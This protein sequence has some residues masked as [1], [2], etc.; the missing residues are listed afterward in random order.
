MQA[1]REKIDQEVARRFRYV[2]IIGGI[3]HFA[4]GLLDIA[5]YPDK[6]KLFIWIRV[7]AC[8][9]VLFNLLVSYTIKKHSL[10]IWISDLSITIAGLSIVTMIYFAEGIA[11]NYYEGLNIVFLALFGANCFYALHNLCVGLIIFTCYL[12]A[13]W[14]NPQPFTVALL[15]PKVFFLGSTISFIYMVTYFFSRQS[16]MDFI[17]SEQLKENAQTLS[18]INQK[19]IATERAKSEFFAN[20]S[21]EL[22]TPL[23]LILGPIKQ[24]LSDPQTTTDQKHDLKVMQRN[25]SVLLK[26]VNELLDLARLDSSKMEVVWEMTDISKLLRFVCGHFEYIARVKMIDFKIK[27][28]SSLVY[29]AD[30]QKVERV[31]F[32]LLSNAFKF[33]PEGGRIDV[34]IKKIDEYI[35]ISVDDSGPGIPTNMRESIFDRF[36]QVDTGD[37]RKYGGTGLGLS[38][39]KE[40]IELLSGQIFVANTAKNGG[41]RIIVRLVK[42]PESMQGVEPASLQT[43][44]PSEIPTLGYTDTASPQHLNLPQTKQSIGDTNVKKPAVLVVEDHAD[45][46]NFIT[47]LLSADYNVMPFLHAKEALKFV[48]VLRPDL[49]ITDLMMPDFSGEQ[50]I[51]AIRKDQAAENIPI[52]VLT[53]KSDPQLAEAIFKWGAQDILIKPFSE[54]ELKA[55]V[56]HHISMK[57]L[58][59]L[60]ET[61]VSAKSSSLQEMAESL[62]RTAA[63][64]TKALDVA[65]KALRTRDEILMNLSHELR[66]PM[67]SVLGW[68][69]LIRNGELDENER[70]AALSTV[71]KN[72]TI[73]QDLINTLLDLVSAQRGEI[74]LT[75]S[76]LDIDTIISEVAFTLGP[77]LHAKNLQVV[78]AQANKRIRIT[79]DAVRLKQVFMAILSNAIK[80]SSPNQIITVD[81]EDD[82]DGVT[83]AI[84][85]QGQGISYE[86]LPHV[87]TYLRQEDPT[88]VRQFGGA[89]VSLALCKNLVELHGGRIEAYSE[90]KYKGSVF[91]VHLPKHMS[92]QDNS[93][94]H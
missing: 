52:I 12:I 51:N 59:D 18:A 92:F 45:M 17:K 78:R 79:A 68:L 64:K 32:N 36:S 8:S 62:I 50:L 93:T 40:F 42:E 55:R 74:Q 26:H 69:E 34:E 4:F 63:E 86:Y 75:P 23:T 35:E 38:I 66:T 87:F 89:G 49:I 5:Q 43:A 20:V 82:G 88:S 41:A 76:I 2:S 27:A 3:L 56:A 94:H 15:A 84:K 73:Q 22:R 72:A 37:A 83:I 85:D 19:L 9:L 70:E 48:D 30:R 46:N 6:A 16:K 58:R 10:F 61:D 60:L 54:S 91:S 28:G 90:G 7:I 65:E 25:A 81:V 67:T 44:R 1:Y 13:C 14:L 39:S 24:L 11:S 53:A 21:H 31:L 29:P 47:Q 71:F 77:L 57:R 80:F 33:T